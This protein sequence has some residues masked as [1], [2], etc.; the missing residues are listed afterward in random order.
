MKLGISSKKISTTVLISM[1]D[2]IFLLLLFLLIASNFSSQ[3]GLPVKLPGS[4]SAQR[5][6]HQVI[7]IVY[8]DAQRVLLNEAPFNLASLGPAL[9]TVY[10]SQ[11]QVVRLSAEKT[12][13]LQD[14]ISVMDVIRAAGFEKI[15]VATDP[16]TQ[17]P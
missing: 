12:T 8:F 17:T 9:E 13:P 7:H 4:T 3:T 6:A 10:N 11:E 14:V 1:T 15:F 5:Q 2:V 16:L